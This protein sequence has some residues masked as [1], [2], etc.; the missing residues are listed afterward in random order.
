MN[1][2][3]WRMMVVV[4]GLL[5]MGAGDIS[6]QY[7]NRG[8]AGR[9]PYRA[10]HRNRQ[11]YYHFGYASASVGYTSLQEGILNV[12]P[13]GGLGN[14]FGVGYEFRYHN[15]WLSVGGQLN[16]HRSQSLLNN[17]SVHQDITFIDA[18][19]SI[20][21]GSSNLDA[22]ATYDIHQKDVMNVVFAEAPVMIGGYYMGFYAGVGAKVS[23]G[24]NTKVTADGSYLLTAKSDK[25]IDPID[26][27]EHEFKTQQSIRFA[28]MVS[29]IGEIG[30]DVLANMETRSPFCHVLKI[31]FYFEVGTNSMVRPVNEVQHMVYN[32]E[33]IHG[34][35]SA[36]GVSFNPYYT[37][38]MITKERVAPFFT[39]VKITYMFGG[40]KNSN[41][42]VAHRGC[43]CYE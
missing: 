15:M 16:W 35:E 10:T 29:V 27:G 6:A 5:L 42:G 36:T 1:G 3:N 26:L 31:G 25:Y 17:Y 39:G 7:M 18:A 8:G 23:Y 14:S 32:G 4:L 41:H 11:D 9:G 21:D 20:K 19:Y 30:Y 40:N 13:V 12:T 22:V 2:K 38:A 28:P 37:S 43:Q 33:A 34:G 24:L